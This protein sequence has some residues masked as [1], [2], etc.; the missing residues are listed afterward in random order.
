MIPA[1]ILFT[2]SVF[3]AVGVV[4]TL[5][6][7]NPDHHP[8]LR[9]KWLAQL[10]VSEAAPLRLLVH[11]LI[12]AALI[13]LGALDYRIG[14]IGFALTLAAWLGYGVVQARTVLAKR[15]LTAALADAGIST[16]AY[17]NIEWRRV[18]IALP[19]RVPADIDRIEGL[20]YAPGLELDVYTAGDADHPRPALLQI[21]G[22]SWRGGNRRQQGRPLMHRLARN[23]WVCV[24]VSYSRSP[25]V[26]FPHHLIDIK[27]A[28]AWMRAEGE[29][30]GIDPARIAVTGGS[31][32]G[33]LA[34][35]AALTA[36]NTSLQ[37]G[38][39]D[40]DVSVQAAVPIYGIYDFLNRN[41]TRDDWTFIH[42]EVMQS[43]PGNDPD[44]YRLASPIDQVNPDAP[45]FFII[46]GAD[47][48]LVPVADARMFAAAL[49]DVS[50][51]PV[52]YAEIPDANHAFDVLD[53]Q[54]THYVISAI[55]RF[56]DRTVVP[57]RATSGPDTTASR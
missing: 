21:H 52:A 26:T 51:A 7:A 54:R 9:T 39:E 32:G 47:D 48:T 42:D 24:A 23:G 2:L 38:F 50:H 19:F 28:L 55:H 36:S 56:L 27:R 4:N 46:H 18:L 25:A 12:T 17:I 1:T 30:W 43:T 6:P 35:L 34:A 41:H 10:T 16:D 13:A 14:R 53:S 45:P 40:A 57:L 33:H 37:P 31:A 8:L 20:S 22:G 15:A 44:A 11:V 3:A 5:R 49:R 29:G